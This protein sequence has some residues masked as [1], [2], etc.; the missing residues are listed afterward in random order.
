MKKTILSIITVMLTLTSVAQEIPFQIKKSEL[1]KDEYKNS[2]IVL[3]ENDGHDGVIIVRSYAGG[4]FSNGFG[5]YFEHYDANLKLI[6]EYEYELKYSKAVKQSSVLGLILDGQNIHI[7]DFIYEKDQ[8]A[9]ICSAMT[10]NINDFNFKQKEL[11]RINSEQ[12]KQF[13]FFSTSGFDSD[14]G[15]A[16]IINEDKSAFA[17]TVDIKNK[18]TETHK[19]FLFNKSLEKKIDHTFKRELKDKKFKYENIEISKDGTL[20]LLGKAYTDDKKKKKEG[21]KYQFELA[22]ITSDSEKIQ[23]FDTNEHFVASLKVIVNEGN[24]SCLG[25]YSDKNDNRFK[26]ISYFQLDPNNLEILKSK[27]NPFTEQ[28]MI[29]KYGKSKDKELKNLSFRK[30][31]T[32][33]NNEILF[34]AEEFYIVSTYVATQYGG[35]WRYTYHYDDIVSALLNSSGEIVWARNINKR[36]STGGDDS[37]IS[38]TSTEKDSNAYFFINTGEKVRKLSND[39]IQFGQTSTNKSNLN[40]IRI[41]QDGNFDYQEV[42]DDKENEVPFMVSNGVI[43]GNSTYFLGRKGKKKQ[44]LKI[45]L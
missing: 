11:F 33:K 40:I 29:D 24:L 31:I 41:N 6:K 35:Y 36:Q 34:N 32:T 21:G 30:I 15:A 5:Y 28:F 22:R 10:S 44:I 25:F 26:G 17:I 13:S 12:I 7:V 18:E 9:Y 23:T 4:S 20:F 39:R 8:K 45:T 37:Y 14:S 16:M 43:S 42:L 3:A 2:S 38:Y 27:F 19:L 1:F